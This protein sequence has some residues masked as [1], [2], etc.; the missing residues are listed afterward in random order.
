MHER[1]RLCG[2]GRG[3]ALRVG[4]AIFLAL[5]AAPVTCEEA[6]HWSATVQAGSARIHP[7]DT[8]RAWFEARV[9]RDLFASGIAS[10]DLG[11]GFSGS[12][13]GFFS[14]T[15]GAE[16][17]PLPKARV[18]PFVRAEIGLLGEP[19]YGGHVAGLGGGLAVSLGSRLVLRG[20]AAWNVHGGET[21]P[22]TYYGGLQSRF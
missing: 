3:L 13:E 7:W 9:G 21:G 19:E 22:V 20:G 12:G 15:A 14:L 18:S 6:P 2:G 10:A 1:P 5:W 8:R 4:A 17:R 16:L 11:V